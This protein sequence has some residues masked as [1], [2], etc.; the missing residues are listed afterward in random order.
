M[1][2]EQFH[3]RKMLMST[4]VSPITSQQRY[5]PEQLAGSG[6]VQDVADA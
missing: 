6:E 3:K 2:S 5:C 4:D 1:N